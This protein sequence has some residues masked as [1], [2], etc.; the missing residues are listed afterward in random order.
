MTNPG[1]SP[2]QISQTTST[3]D[4]LRKLG[5]PIVTGAWIIFTANFTDYFLQTKKNAS[6]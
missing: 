2:V 3:M 1:G 5:L 4:S 6:Q